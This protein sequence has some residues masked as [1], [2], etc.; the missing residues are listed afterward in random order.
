VATEVQRLPRVSLSRAQ[1][2]RLI[3]VGILVLIAVG[4][5]VPDFVRVAYP[6]SDFGYATDG[7]GVVVSAPAAV[8]KRPRFVWRARARAT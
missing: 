2:A 3:V 8:P 6:L 1:W 4:R 7:D 5:V